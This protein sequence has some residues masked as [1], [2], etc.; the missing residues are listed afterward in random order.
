MTDSTVQCI[1][2]NM[3]NLRHELLGESIFTSFRT[4]D[5]HVYGES[6][7]LERLFLGVKSCFGLDRLSFEHF[8][9][10]FFQ[11]NEL[12]KLFKQYPN[13]YFRLTFYAKEES[14]LNKFKFA[15]EE[16]ARDVK[17]KPA[18]KIKNGLRVSTWPYPFAEGYKLCKNGSYYYHLQAR[19]QA[20]ANGHDDAAFVNSKRELLELST[21]NIVFRKKN[22]Q[23]AFPKNKN[24]LE[25]TTQ[26]LFKDFL[27]S[28]GHGFEHEFIHYDKLDHYCNAYAFNAVSLVRDLS[29]IDDHKFLTSIDQQWQD[30]FL[31]YLRECQS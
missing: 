2:Q 3:F 11:K 14:D 21:S 8:E 30:Q 13:H 23:F 1:Y 15:L 7:H 20:L 5:G 31:I 22:G 19:K 18:A 12:K 9:K 26:Q 25:G 24:I 10:Y 29:S 27:S 28:A 17:I 4:W 6:L 16:I